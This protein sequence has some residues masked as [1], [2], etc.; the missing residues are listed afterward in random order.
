MAQINLPPVSGFG[1]G[2]FQAAGDNAGGRMATL[3]SNLISVLTIFGGLAFLTWFVIGALTWI[4]SVGSPKQVD[5]AK[6]Q[7]GAALTGLFV[8]ILSYAILSLLSRI[9]GLD[10]LNFE[11]L[12]NRLK[13]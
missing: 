10:I 6:G 11:D 1:Q 13:P 3:I 9:T 12:V 5:K 2:F 7:M 4:N 8:L